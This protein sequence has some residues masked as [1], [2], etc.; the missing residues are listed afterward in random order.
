M[1]IS[2][3]EPPRKPRAYRKRSHPNLKLRHDGA[4]LITIP[5]ST[6]ITGFGLVLSYQKARAGKLPGAVRLDGR[7]Y[8]N[9]PKLMAWLDGLGDTQNVA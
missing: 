5:E 1:N 4:A 8:V 6:R 9:R 3:K 7:W 2:K